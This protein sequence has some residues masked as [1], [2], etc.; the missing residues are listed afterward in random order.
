MRTGSVSEPSTL[1]A[2]VLFTRTVDELPVVGPGGVAMVK[3]G[4]DETVVGGREV[5]RPL[6]GRGSTVPLRTVEEATDLLRSSLKRS[7][8]DGELHVRKA[9]LG[10]AE[11]GIE[12]T[13]RYLEPCYAFLVE[14]VGGLVDSKQVVVIPAARTGPM[15]SA[16]TA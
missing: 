9:R 10:Y 8:T 11:A 1:D 16:F 7:G 2:G 6:A 14:T 15:A 3:I 5:W 13:Q 12:A 4:T